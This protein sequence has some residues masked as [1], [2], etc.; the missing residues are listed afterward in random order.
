[1]HLA[2]GKKTSKRPAQEFVKSTDQGLLEGGK[3]SPASC[4]GREEKAQPGEKMG[5]GSALVGGS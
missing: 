4:R 3:Q 1:M 2:A 5:G